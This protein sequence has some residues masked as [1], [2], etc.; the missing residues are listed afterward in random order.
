MA[1]DGEPYSGVLGAFPYAFRASGSR[2]FRSYVVLGGLLALLV[3]VLFGVALVVLIART[4]GVGGGTFTFARAFF[5]TV[6]FAVVA[7]LVAPVLL[8]AR[9][10]RRTGSDP[11]YDA[12]LAATGYLFVGSLYLAV[13]VST[14]ATQQEPVTGP[15]AP[16]VDALYGLPRLA[17]VPILVGATA[18][19]AL[20]HWRFR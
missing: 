3:A 6:G 10:H 1:G 19:V 7:P 5:V 2:L 9:R 14:P 20:A 17:S 4:A 12:A 15:L 13:V 11:R 18:L 8:V 16:V